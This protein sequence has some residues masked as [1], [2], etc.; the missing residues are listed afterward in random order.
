M[1]TATPEETQ[2]VQQAFEAT[3]APAVLADVQERERAFELA[4]RKARVYASS[5]LVPKRYQGN[6][7]NVIIAQNMAE[8]LNADLLMVMQNLYV[9]HGTPAWSAKFLIATFN[10]CG[11]FSKIRYRFV[12][13]RGKDSWGC[14]AYAT[15]LATGEEITG[16]EITMKLAK[17]EGWVS[18]SGSKWKTMPEKMLRYRA[19]AWMIDTVAPEISMGIMTADEAEDCG[20]LHPVSVVDA[21]NDLTA[22]LKAPAEKEE[23]EPKPAPIDYELQ[24][25]SANGDPKA[26]DAVGAAIAA[27]ESLSEKDRDEWADILGKYLP[28]N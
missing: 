26:L 5:D 20:P 27:D 25:I 16:P 9:V 17:D 11:D 22:R 6:I 18:K 3:A 14:I 1:S 21:T 7:A 23:P 28:S 10:K 13:E 8:R 24:M 19:A 12:G 4:Q 15:E 2:I